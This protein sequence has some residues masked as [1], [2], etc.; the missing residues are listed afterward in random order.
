MIQAE[1]VDKELPRSLPYRV[2]LPPCASQ[3]RGQLPTLYLLH[4]FARTY[5]HWHALYADEF[6]QRTLFV[7]TAFPFLIQ[8]PWVRLLP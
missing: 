2:Y 4:R 5:A 7:D 3:V 8:M 1:L 6:P